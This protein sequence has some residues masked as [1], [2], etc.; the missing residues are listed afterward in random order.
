MFLAVWIGIGVL[1]FVDNGLDWELGFWVLLITVWVENWDFGFLTV[2][3]GIGILGLVSTS[4][5]FVPHNR[6][7]CPHIRQGLKIPV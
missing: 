1:G 6:R 2:W 3:V 4:A 5:R 7:F